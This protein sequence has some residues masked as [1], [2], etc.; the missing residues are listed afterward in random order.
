MAPG[1]EVT[2]TPA[3]VMCYEPTVEGFCV[4]LVECQVPREA[5]EN[6]LLAPQ[7]HGHLF[8]SM[9]GPNGCKCLGSLMVGRERLEVI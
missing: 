6:H 4:C 3:V 1:R 2:E 9:C 5:V 8:L 7:K